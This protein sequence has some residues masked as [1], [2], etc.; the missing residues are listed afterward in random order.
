MLLFPQ[1]VKSRPDA[2]IEC[3]QRLGGIL[4]YYHR[5][6]ALVFRFGA[7]G[8]GGGLLMAGFAIA[9]APAGTAP[10]YYFDTTS[11]IPYLGSHVA[12][13]SFTLIDGTAYCLLLKIHQRR[14]KIEAAQYDGVCPEVELPTPSKDID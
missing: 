5:K 3:H 12:C 14:M 8:K 9:L 7:A 13:L 11:P 2:A 6:A 4:R 10:T 1:K